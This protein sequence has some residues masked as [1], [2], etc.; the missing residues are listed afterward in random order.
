MSRLLPMMTLILAASSVVCGQSVN[1][2]TATLQ[3]TIVQVEAIPLSDTLA[4]E[5][6]RA[7][8]SNSK[9]GAVNRVPEA[10]N[11]REETGGRFWGSAEYLLWKMK[12]SNLPPLITTGPDTSEA[13]L[14]EPG[15]VVAF[16]GK[17][18]QG[19]FPGGRF[20]VGMWLNEKRNVGVELSY[21][22][23]KEKT[24][25]FQVSS[26]GLPGSQAISRPFFDIN[27]NQEGVLFVASPLIFRE[28]TPPLTFSGSSTATS[29]SRLQGAASNLIYRLNE[30]HF[31]RMSLLA[32]FRYLN[33][34]EG[35]TITDV[36]D[37]TNGNHDSDF[38]QFSTRNRFYGGQVGARSS[39]SKHRLR[40]ELEARVAMG[41]NRQ[42]V[43]INGASSN[44][45]FF[46]FNSEGGVLALI[47]N[48]GQYHR[49]EFTIMPEVKAQFAYKF[50]RYLRAFIGYDFL[51]WNKV[52]RPGEQIDR[53][54]N[55]QLVL[56][57]V[58]DLINA[59]SCP[60]FSA[61]QE[62]HNSSNYQ[63]T[64]EVL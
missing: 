54:G 29:P 42:S 5:Q 40:L 9:A 28:T 6:S 59:L 17:L 24:F 37:L 27:L 44:N 47:T 3:Q 38:D 48:I 21:F 2:S 30:S 31:G 53:V 15:T 23:L 57:Q 26:S 45:H 50:T 33:L 32:G 41:S 55:D 34:K 35:L 49:S 11:E 61:W 8:Q 46:P 14:G 63:T 13:V 7:A 43:E 18:D 16:G 60:I 39:F 36:S 25:N 4:A 22:F 56:C 58:S 52:V 19:K 51:Y 1:Q 62:Q 12:R 64:H 20:T 10:E